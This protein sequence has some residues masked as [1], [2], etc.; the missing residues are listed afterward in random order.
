MFKSAR[1]SKGNG[2]SQ[3][4]HDRGIWFSTSPVFVW[5]TIVNFVLIFGGTI[6]TYI[7][8][9]SIQNTYQEAESRI[10]DAKAK[11]QEAS[12]ELDQS[13]A[14]AAQAKADVESLTN[15]FERFDAQLS[16]LRKESERK[17]GAIADEARAQLNQLKVEKV[18]I[19]ST[20]RALEDDMKRT[21]AQNSS[22]IRE[23]VGKHIE[24]AGKV[25]QESS[26]R[27]KGLG[28]EISELKLKIEVKNKE[29]Q[30]LQLT[31]NRTLESVRETDKAMKAELVKLQHSRAVDPA[32]LWTNSN[33]ALRSVYV[34]VFVLIVLC[35]IFSI[36]AVLRSKR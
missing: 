6:Y 31:V 3:T 33:P 2:A 22:T 14:K 1:S 7:N 17:L 19:G 9:R 23:E 28:P 5:V 15:N 4:K 36:I 12:S 20:L 25:V 10:N 18:S 34:G 13:R 32:M 24:A 11:Y 27:L 29:I 30:D 26:D 21:I 35:F 8:V 16:E